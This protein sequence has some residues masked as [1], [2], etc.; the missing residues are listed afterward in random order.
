MI[1][2]KSLWVLIHGVETAQHII[3]FKLIMNRLRKMRFKYELILLLAI[4][5]CHSTRC[6]SICSLWR[7]TTLIAWPWPSASV[8]AQTV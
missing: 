5:I 6:H 7:S 3:L 1:V 8:C 4:S 2:Y